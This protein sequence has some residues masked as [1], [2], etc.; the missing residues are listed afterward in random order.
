MHDL[1][2]NLNLFFFF[3]KKTLIELVHDQVITMKSPYIS[4][5]TAW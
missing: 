4:L 2:L 3:F 5:L 1:K